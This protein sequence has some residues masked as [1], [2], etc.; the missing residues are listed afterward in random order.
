MPSSDEK[1]QSPGLP[2][3]GHLHEHRHEHVHHGGAAANHTNHAHDVTYADMTQQDRP[4][5]YEKNS[6]FPAEKTSLA[7]DE[8]LGN[9]DRSRGSNNPESS[10]G[11]LKT[12]YRKLRAPIHLFIWLVFTA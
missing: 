4:Q 11:F 8:E 12:W 3:P 6:D 5:S 2:E 1:F 7:T 10:T 9:V